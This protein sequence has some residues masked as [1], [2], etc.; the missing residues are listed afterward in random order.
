MPLFQKGEDGEVK[1][2]LNVWKAVKEY[3]K[4]VD[5]LKATKVITK[6]EEKLSLESFAIWF[7]NEFPRFIEARE[8]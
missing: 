2:H 5:K 4:Y 3:R 7:E 1:L 6:R 8:K